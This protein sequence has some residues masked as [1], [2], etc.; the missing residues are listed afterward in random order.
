MKKR[1]EKNLPEQADIRGDGK[2]PIISIEADNLAEASYK[3]IIACHDYGARVETPKH[4]P[5]MTLGYDADITVRVKNPDSEPKVYNLAV[6]DDARGVMQ[7][8]LEVTHGI[9]NHWKKNEQHPEW[10]GYTYNERFVDQLPF[11]FKRIKHDWDEKRKITG[12]DYQFTIWRPGED[13]ITE[14]Q[15]PPCFQRGNIRFLEDKKGDITLNYITEWRSRDLLKA[16]NENNLAQVELQKL[17][18]AKVSDILNVPIKLGAYI[19]RSSSLHL[20]GL[21]IDRD[22]LETQIGEMK[23]ESYKNRSMPLNEYFSYM[24]MEAGDPIYLK[25]LVAAQSD[26]EAKGHGLNQSSTKLKELGYNLET[27]NYPAEW[28]S[29]PKSWDAEPDPSKL[30]RVPK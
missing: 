3:S 25:K 8:I 4:R 22:G 11:I 13:I 15:D 5:G 7:Y 1:A 19:D 20:Y 10:W 28:D 26:A 30:A 21:Y 18:A 27:Y 24:G 12:R 16:W 9:H 23:K 2:I 14:Q 17:F 29:W 6:H